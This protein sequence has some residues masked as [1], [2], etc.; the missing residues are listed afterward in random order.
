MPDLSSITPIKINIGIANKMK[1]FDIEVA[2]K[3]T[4]T[5]DSG[6][7]NKKLNITPIPP[8]AKDTGSPNNRVAI[9]QLKRTSVRTSIL[10]APASL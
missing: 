5:K 2:R 8:K 1:E 9:R 10:K 4:R 7:H 6:P 3:A